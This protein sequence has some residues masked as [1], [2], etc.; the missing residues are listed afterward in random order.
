MPKIKTVRIVS[1]H[2][3]ASDNDDSIPHGSSH[4]PRSSAGP[5]PLESGSAES[6]RENSPINPFSI[7]SDKGEATTEDEGLRKN[8]IGNAGQR[9]TGNMTMKMSP[10]S[11]QKTL[12]K[13]TF[14]TGT[15]DTGERSEDSIPNAATGTTKLH[16]DVDEFKR[17]LLTGE[18]SVAEASA[19]S[20]LSTHSQGTQNVGDT[21]SNTDA[22][23]ISRHSIFEPLP[24]ISQDTPRTSHEVSPSGEERQ[25]PVQSPSPRTERIRPPA[26]KPRHGNPASGTVLQNLS[27]QGSGL[28][29]QWSDNSNTTFPSWPSVD[30]PQTP[31]DLNKPLPLTPAVEPL[32]GTVLQPALSANRRPRSEYIKTEGTQINSLPLKR[33]PPAPPLAR[34]HSQRRPISL[35]GPSGRSMQISEENLAESK[36]QSQWM[37]LASP[38]PPPPPP[39]RS[40][41]TRSLSTAS[42]SSSI[43][44]F[45]APSTTSATDDENTNTSKS[46]PPLPPSRTPSIS[47]VKRPP[48]PSPDAKSSPTMGPPLPPRRRGSSHGSVTQSISSGEYRADRYRSDSGASSN[49]PVS[50]APLGPGVDDKDVLADLTALQR[51]VDEL[52]GKLK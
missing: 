36:R 28:S 12:V 40:G 4:N 52:R 29:L 13:N 34:R 9:L 14:T 22:S 6:S 15:L 44:A 3:S 1:P 33:E 20:T 2:P 39:R 5:P 18:T 27:R 50:A 38:K 24:G 23:S 10:N 37:P 17:L 47:S 51:E 45:R 31:T 19:L 49:P 48:R 42:N 11:L 32:D 26:P 30:S 16:Y 21:S 35:I 43:S 7:E 41:P 25:L 8:T 46:P